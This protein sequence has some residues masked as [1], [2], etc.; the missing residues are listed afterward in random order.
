MVNNSNLGFVNSDYS[1]PG[2]LKQGFLFAIVIADTGTARIN[3]WLCSAD[4]FAAQ[5]LSA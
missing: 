3:T 4:V 5:L 2:L 1:G